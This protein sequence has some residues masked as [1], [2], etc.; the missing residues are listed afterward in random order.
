M[1]KT[2]TRV[3]TMLSQ[4]EA[5]EDRRAGR[6]PAFRRR[7][8]GRRTARRIVDTLLEMRNYFAFLIKCLPVF[9]GEKR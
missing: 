2:R 7:T 8:T 5:Q 4:E 6:E 1:V 9:E 3:R